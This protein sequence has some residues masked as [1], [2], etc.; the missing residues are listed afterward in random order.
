[1]AAPTP[2]TD[3][4][5]VYALF[6]TGDLAALDRDGGL[7]W[8]RSLVSDYPNITNQVGMAASPVLS[9]N[10]LLLPL[11]NAG[12][13]FA[14]GLDKKTG[15]NRW[16]VKRAREIN[17]VTPLVFSLD[18]RP[19]ALFS[20]RLEAT[21]YDPETGKVRFTFADDRL[22]DIV[23]PTWGQG[24]LF[25]SGSQLLALKPAVKGKSEVLWKTAHLRTG[26]ATP[27]Y[28]K[29]DL[30]GLTQ[31]TLNR[32]SGKDG[33]VV[34]KERVVGPF[35]ASPVIGDD[36]LYA[37]NEKGVTTVIQLGDK[38]KVLARNNLD[39]TILAT[40]AISGGAIYLR[41]DKHLW[42]IGGKGKG[43]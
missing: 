7:L 9:G 19:A 40:P 10:T 31:V 21:A 18:G 43:D 38:P 24:M 35:A 15:K 32:V 29:G 27:V 14:A 28:Y 4:D 13:S 17:W 22:S 1:M 23:S 3:G 41:S 42:C 34:W 2:V 5:H 11:E 33:E 25:I 20:T 36:K 8:Y 6:A 16:K 39:E 26:F 12:E 30:Y 37:V